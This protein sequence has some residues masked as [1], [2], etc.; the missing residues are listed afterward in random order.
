MRALESDAR[1][2]IAGKSVAIVANAPEILETDY[3]PI[4]DGHDVVLRMNRAWP[5]EANADAIGRRTDILTG[6]IIGPLPDVPFSFLPWIWWLKYTSMGVRH[7]KD[8]LEWPPFRRTMI[9]HVS[10]SYI[11][12]LDRLF[13]QGASSGPIV[14]NT[15]QALGARKVSVFGMTCWGQLES[16]QAT[17]WW[18]HH[19]RYAYLDEKTCW[20][21][22]NA[23]V[24]WLRDR[25]TMVRPL[26]YEAR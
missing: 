8:C 25:L 24:M 19:P 21:N 11:Q 9:W 2:Y 18:K 16:G 26:H 14:I 6:G 4:I 7:L 13:G 5:T 10:S 23:E 20:H 1:D 17:H 12:P 22:A 3:G 15:C